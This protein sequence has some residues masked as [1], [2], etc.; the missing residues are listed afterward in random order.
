MDKTHGPASGPAPG[1]PGGHPGGSAAQAG[2]PDS[3]SRLERH[4]RGTRRVTAAL[5]LLWLATG[6]CAVFFARELSG[7]T[8][9]GWPLSFYLAAQGA[10]LV[11]LAIIA[12]Y[13]WRMRCLDRQY[14]AGARG[15]GHAGHAGEGGA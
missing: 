6:F 9:F 3:R 13:A 1:T 12:V 5:L 10:S 4:W 11:Y 8:L 15:A 14:A 7:L 2:G